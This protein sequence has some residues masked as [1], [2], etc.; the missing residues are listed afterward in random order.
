[1][2]GVAVGAIAAA[3]NPA[4]V[5]SVFEQSKHAWVEIPGA[6]HYQQSSA[7]NSS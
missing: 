2:I 4:P 7:K 6:E 3:D 5:K 1:M